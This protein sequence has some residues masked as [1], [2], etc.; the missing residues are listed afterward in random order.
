MEHRGPDADAADAQSDRGDAHVLD[1]GVGEEALVVV[2]APQEQ[3]AH[4][5]REDA[6]QQ[7]Y[8]AYP[9]DRFGLLHDAIDA[10]NGQKAGVDQPRRDQRRGGCRRGEIGVD[11][12]R[13]ERENLHLAAVTAEDQQ[14]G[15]FQV[16]RVAAADAARQLLV[17]Q[18]T[19]AQR[20]EQQD[21]QIGRGDAY[22]A[23]ED[24]FPR[25]FER[26]RRAA[27]VDDAGGA[28]GR[29]FEEDPRHGDVAGE[30]DARD[31]RG[32]QHQQREVETILLDRIVAQVDARVDEDEG[33]DDRQQREEERACRVEAEELRRYLAVAFGDDVSDQRQ[34]DEVEGGA[35]PF[36]R[37][38][39]PGEG[40][41]QSDQC[42]EQKVECDHTRVSLLRWSAGRCRR[43]GSGRRS[44]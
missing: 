42:G 39:L 2:R 34:L 40:R 26:L 36:D 28:E 18:R 17:A 15:D 35:Q 14:K 9:A 30:V 37:A 13:V 33:R 23:D 24:V 29:G 21:A 19:V 22:R 7:Q 6:R 1:R 3:R 10:E 20:R 27:V 31:G 11:A 32:E 43:Y 4:G 12:D 16:E 5:Q 8:V 41:G 38:A 44:W 25:R